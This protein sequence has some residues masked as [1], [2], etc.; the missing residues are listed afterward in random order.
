MRI[1]TEKEQR[2]IRLKEIEKS[3]SFSQ[4]KVDIA[5]K[6]KQ[7]KANWGIFSLITTENWLLDYEY[8]NLL[9]QLSLLKEY[10]EIIQSELNKII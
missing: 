7:N 3:I 9:L 8:Q 10:R 5:L 4:N 2:E 6:R 1:L